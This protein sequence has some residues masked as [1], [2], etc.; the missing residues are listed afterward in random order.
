MAAIKKRNKTVK[1]ILTVM[2][3]LII[4]FIGAMYNP[5]TFGHAVTT[6]NMKGGISRHPVFLGLHK[7]KYV[8]LAT[9][10]SR[11]PYKSNI[12]VMLEGQQPIDY[13]LSSR[14]PPEINLGIHKFYDFED[15]TMKNLK[16]GEKFM[17]AVSIKPKNKIE[18]PVK[19]DIKFYDTDSNK[20]VLTIPVIFKELVNFHISREARRGHGHYQ[21]RDTNSKTH[22]SKYSPAKH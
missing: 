9:G 17:V 5:P 14:L 8:I 21:P 12:K 4:C 1:I 2:I 7:N 20:V 15:H 22:H 13:E 19:Y 10:T 11:L 18:K 16:P 6:I 3:T